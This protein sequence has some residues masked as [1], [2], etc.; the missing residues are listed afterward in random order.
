[1]YN[2]VHFVS[3]QRQSTSTVLMVSPDHFGFNPQ[4]AV[5]NP[6]Q[7]TIRELHVSTEEV[8]RDAQKEFDAMVASLEHNGVK[9]LVLPSPTGVVTPDAVF[10]N[11]WFSTH[12]DGRLVFYPLQT[13]NRREERQPELLF[14]TLKKIG[15]NYPEVIDLTQDEEKGLILESTGS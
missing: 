2:L 7:H 8:R 6:F 5:T 12:E 9:V 15:I 11:N 14:K 10:P 4:T 3:M 1:M 13:P